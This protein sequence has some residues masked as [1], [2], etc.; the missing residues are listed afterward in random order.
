MLPYNGTALTE[1]RHKPST[2]HV[3][4]ATLKTNLTSYHNQPQSA[5]SA[6]ALQLIEKVAKSRHFIHRFQSNYLLA[7]GPV[8][9]KK[10]P[11][12]WF[13]RIEKNTL[14]YIPQQKKCITNDS[15]L[16]NVIWH[17]YFVP[18][19]TNIFKTFFFLIYFYY[20]KRSLM[21]RFRNHY[22]MHI[23]RMKKLKKPLIWMISSMI[24]QYLK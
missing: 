12:K 1:K 4:W 22:K 9:L 23:N 19:N 8:P 2:N 11:Q 21:F 13:F 16:E 5:C 20:R 14:L 10:R 15:T 3:K 24:D 7:V 6:L 18:K 17:G